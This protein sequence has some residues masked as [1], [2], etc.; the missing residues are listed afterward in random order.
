MRKMVK[1]NK[2]FTLIELV[3]VIAILGVLAAV[4][5]TMFPKLSS[6]SRSGA[7]KTRATQIKSAISTYIAESGDSSLKGLN[8]GVSGTAIAS[9]T[10]TSD[11]VD[12][13]I[14]SLQTAV[15]LVSGGTKYGPYLENVGGAAT[16]LA[17]S[18][19]PQQNGY[20]WEIIYDADTNNVSVNAIP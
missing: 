8:G 7:D 10:L 20:E 13:I 19:A 4:A 14:V 6:S 16:P 9:G 17:K 11:Q 18:Y 15:E 3:I 2:G 5:I 12:T 1:N